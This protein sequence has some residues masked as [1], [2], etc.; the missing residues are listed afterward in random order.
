VV[1][2][3]VPVTL[4]CAD[5]DSVCCA[6]AREQSIA[7]VIAT[8]IDSE[9]RRHFMVDPHFVSYEIFIL[10]SIQREKAAELIVDQKIFLKIRQ[11]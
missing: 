8:N 11:S 1:T 10:I 5:G 2:G 9:F 4:G 3:V 7:S 6:T